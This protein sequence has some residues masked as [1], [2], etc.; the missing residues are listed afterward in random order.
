DG[1]AAPSAPSTSGADDDSV[2][3]ADGESAAADGGSVNAETVGADG[4]TDDSNGDAGDSADD[5][6]DSTDKTNGDNSKTDD[7]E[8]GAGDA[9]A[10]NKSTD[11][12]NGDSAKTDTAETSA[13]DT[14]DSKSVSSK[15]DAAEAGDAANAAAAGD[16]SRP[17]PSRHLVSMYNFESGAY[18]VYDENDLL[19]AA[20]PE[21][22]ATLNYADASQAEA[23]RE[24][25][26]QGY[27]EPFNRGLLVML[28]VF[29]A[30]A[31][32]LAYLSLRRR[33]LTRAAQKR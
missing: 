9:G 19:T 12:T 2:K 3:P 30:I 16:L 7:A 17:A 32:L 15:T 20:Q 6:N 24:L 27:K 25:A 28:I 31:A 1:G 11:K 26:A 10:A 23:L 4:D 22:I 18:E 8:A 33:R 21:P 13:G 29:G 5:A 14:G